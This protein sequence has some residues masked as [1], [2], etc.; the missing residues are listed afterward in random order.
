MRLVLRNATPRSDARQLADTLNRFAR[1]GRDLTLVMREIA[2]A[3]KCFRIERAPDGSHWRDL[4]KETELLRS[5][6]GTWT[7]Q[8][9]QDA[10]GLVGSLTGRYDAHPAVAGANLPY[11][12]KHQLGHQE[13]GE[14]RVP[15]RSD[16]L[17]AEITDSVV[18]RSAADA[19][20]EI[21]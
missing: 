20:H 12:A 11:A 14:P 16:D 7:G 1:S 15:A 8:I 10:G 3:Q 4:S 18:R 2:D 19:A 17:D 21:L 5:T 13:P 6:R 9:L